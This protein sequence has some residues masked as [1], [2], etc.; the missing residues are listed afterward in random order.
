MSEPAIVLLD[1]V[2]DRAEALVSRFDSLICP[3]SMERART[4]LE[5]GLKASLDLYR[6]MAFAELIDAFPGGRVIMAEIVE[7]ADRLKP[8][9]SQGSTGEFH[10]DYVAFRLREA[11]EACLAAQAVSDAMAAERAKYLSPG[12]AAAKIDQF[13]HEALGDAVSEADHLRTLA[14]ACRSL[15]DAVHRASNG[16][17]DIHQYVRDLTNAC[18]HWRSKVRSGAQYLHRSLPALKL[19]A[20]GH[21]ASAEEIANMAIVEKLMDDYAE[22]RLADPNDPSN[23]PDLAARRAKALDEFLDRSTG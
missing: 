13:L 17:A 14:D 16:P 9:W 11:C 19:L 23:D 5:A 21:D 15:R 7:T 20:S 2:R 6:D 18:Q 4:W 22:T 1:P 8:S 10:I 3:A 12:L